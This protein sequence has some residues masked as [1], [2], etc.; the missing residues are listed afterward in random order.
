MQYLPTFWSSIIPPSWQSSNSTR[1]S[2]SPVSCPPDVTLHH[3]IM[4]FLLTCS[5]PFPERIFQRVWSVASFFKFQSPLISLRSCSSCLNLL[6]HLLVPCVFPL[7]I[8]FRW[9]FLHKMCP[10][11]LALFHFNICRM[12]FSSLT[13]EFVPLE[14][15][16][17]TSYFTN[18]EALK[19]G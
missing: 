13:T 11:Q 8:C 4:H 9:Q 2:L 6:P 5:Q 19:R 15:R 10:I 1:S 3:T 18:N 17:L 16:L 14:L 7:I 12:I